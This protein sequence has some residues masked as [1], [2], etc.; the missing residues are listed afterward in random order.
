[1]NNNYTQTSKAIRDKKV[2]NRDK[3]ER[4]LARSKVLTKRLKNKKQVLEHKN[5]SAI[6]N[7]KDPNKPIKKP[8]KL[9]GNFKRM[10]KD[11]ANPNSQ[12]KGAGR[13]LQL[14]GTD[15]LAKR[16]V[17]SGH[18]ELDELK[19]NNLEKDLLIVNGFKKQVNLII[20]TQKGLKIKTKAYTKA[21]KEV[22]EFL[23]RGEYKN[24]KNKII[25]K[26][27]SAWQRLN[28]ACEDNN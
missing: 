22:N 10:V 14:T 7:S 25:N 12:F 18:S 28:L 26:N 8:S 16:F 19:I 5:T 15:K 3:K 1:M 6:L 2:N 13:L 11:M 9:K 20:D 27:F 17:D 21:L 23:K 24:L 4:A